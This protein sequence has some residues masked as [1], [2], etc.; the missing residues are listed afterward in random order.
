MSTKG[1]TRHRTGAASAVNPDHVGWHRVIVVGVLL[2]L[3]AAIATSWNGLVFVGKTQ[4]LPW[5]PTTAF[6]IDVP[7]VVLTLARGALRKRGIRARGLLW[8]ILALT[9]YSSAANFLHTVSEAGFDTI[10]QRLGATSNALAPWLILVMTEVL[11][12]VVTR[13]IRPRAPRAKAKARRQR[14]TTPRAAT[15]PAAPTLFEP[16][17]DPL[18]ALRESA[19]R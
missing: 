5:P 10:A 12:L 15:A 9:I 17:G 1:K 19:E 2:S 7:L 16:E 11:W 4:L 18:G 14:S 3:I 6:M 8:G 13:P